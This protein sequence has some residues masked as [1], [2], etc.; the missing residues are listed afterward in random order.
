[1]GVSIETVLVTQNS[2]RYKSGVQ[3][4]YLL[5]TDFNSVILGK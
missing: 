3:T 4:T 2:Q 1:V 5:A